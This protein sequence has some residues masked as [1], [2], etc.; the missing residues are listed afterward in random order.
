MIRAGPA[1]SRA[2]WVAASV[3]VAVPVLALCGVVLADHRLVELGRE[4]L[5][6]S[7]AMV[8][9][10]AVISATAVGAVLLVR[11]SR[12][13]AGWCFAGLGVSMALSGLLDSYAGVGAVADPGSLPLADAA[14]VLGDASFI[15]WIVL[16]ALALHLTPT[17]RPLSPRWAA[18]AK[19]TVVAAALWWVSKLLSDVPLDPPFATVQNPMAV[20]SAEGFVE[21]VRGL[22]A[23]V[24]GLGLLAA[25]ASLLVRFRGAEHTGRRQLHW[26][27]L[28]VIPL[29][30]FVGLSF[31]GASTGR[32]VLVILST[33][34]FVALIPIAAGLAIAQYHLYDVDRVLSRAATY[35]LMSAAV[36]AC[37]VAGV[38]LLNA[39][40]TG[41]T[42]DDRSALSA[43]VAAVAVAVVLPL[44]S[45]LQD[46]VDR[47]F[48]RRRFAALSVIRA[49]ADDPQP[50]AT[51]DTVLREALG[52]PSISVAY[53]IAPRA[54]WVSADGVQQG[55][56]GADHV[57]ASRHDQPVAR[58]SY[59]R[60]LCDPELVAA[61]A[62][63]ALP[64]LENTGLR[65]ALALEL[66]EVQASQARIADAQLRE[67]QRIERDLHDGAQQRL[68]AM[69][70]Q[71]SAAV[72]NGDP[73]R[74]EEAARAG[75]DEARATVR[76]LRE[77]A[78]GLHP[79]AL[80]DGGL[81]AAV[82]ELAAR[83]PG[84]LEPHVEEQR[85]PHLVEGTAWFI[86]CEAVA[87]AL[88]H[89][90]GA[91]VTVDIRSVAGCLVVKVSDD[92][93]GIADPEGGGL[94]GLADRAAAVGG[95]LRVHSNDHGT[96]IEA[97]LPCA[98]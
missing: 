90:T 30:L 37:Y 39:L 20:T 59:D 86:V 35:V 47:R 87:N 13:P 22:S 77:I 3:A 18:A 46:A 71:L 81:A 61:V 60:D 82:D 95:R 2:A 89:T 75:V 50:G 23:A 84:R 8:Y 43:A 29:P 51:V 55:D 88:K 67:R 12:N 19:V 74:L 83:L 14:A 63:A 94:R 44:R 33:S 6:E 56:R 58:V 11:R 97:E 1:T 93:A 79:A 28:A 54:Q 73:A 66:V 98:S 26:L 80:A 24:T 72:V 52:D 9:G 65:A 85:H 10:V 17:G 42:A 21:A 64:A 41:L 53:W 68:L 57:L 49:Y 25:G 7:A 91:L 36:L 69:A 32:P 4:D 5:R 27:A 38:V 45:R 96:L 76:E 40:L 15:P 16:V 48:S 62:D 70:M 34:G 92:G 78:N 31:F